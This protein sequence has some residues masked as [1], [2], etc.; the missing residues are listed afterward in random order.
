MEL[1][2]R[3]LTNRIFSICHSLEFDQFLSN[4]R[5]VSLLTE[6]SSLIAQRNNLI[7][8]IQ[9]KKEDIK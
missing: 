1:A 5:R 8:V 7:E 4:E 9:K 6:L 2:L 3:Q